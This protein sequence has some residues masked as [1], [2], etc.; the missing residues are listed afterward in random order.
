MKKVVL[1]CSSWHNCADAMAEPLHEM[2]EKRLGEKVT[3]SSHGGY[4]E[5]ESRERFLTDSRDADVVLTDAWN[6]SKDLRGDRPF[7][8]MM[9]IVAD[10]Q[11]QNPR[12]WCFAQTF[13][14]CMQ[15]R[16]DVHQIA[17]P[18]GGFAAP[19][20]NIIADYLAGKIEK[21][22]VK[23]CY[24][25]RSVTRGFNGPGFER[26]S[27]D[28]DEL[29]FCA[30]PHDDKSKG[31]FMWMKN[32]AEGREHVWEY[33]DLVEVQESGDSVVVR[34]IFHGR[35]EVYGSGGGYKTPY[36][37]HFTFTCS[38]EKALAC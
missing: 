32:G 4:L 19:V 38:L 31:T 33:G 6:Y 12:V 15:N 25:L 37:I 22:G 17:T 8:S 35:Q 10:V 26:M 14:A 21:D 1:F 16:R 7:V 20:M 34:G 13:D 27:C 23:K 30:T 11:R 36:T 28:G 18:F 5:G 9:N 29:V 3:F 2:L 24:F